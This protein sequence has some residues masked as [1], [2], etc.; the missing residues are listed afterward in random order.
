MNRSAFAN[1]S[2]LLDTVTRYIWGDHRNRPGWQVSLIRTMR[3]IWAV[4]RD[5]ME[6]QL[7]L[8]A[9]SLVY[10]TLLSLVPLLAISFSILKG[11]GVHNQIEPFLANA[12]EPLGER[13]D[14]VVNRIVD[15][16]DNVQVGVLGSVGF[17][18]LFYTVGSMMQK[19]EHAF[20]DVWQ[21]SSKRTF[22]QRFKDYLSVIVIGPVL[23]FA[24]LGIL[25][26]VMS[27]PLMERIVSIQPVSAVVELLARLVPIAI[28]TLAFTFIYMFVPHTRVRL[29]PAL[30]GGLVAG[31]LWNLLGWMFAAFVSQANRYTAIYSGFATPILFMMWLY[32]GWLVLLAGSAI[33]FYRQH[34]EYLSGRQLTGNLSS[35]DRER[36]ALHCICV[37]GERFYRGGSA[38]DADALANLL[39]VPSNAI[40]QVLAPLQRRGLIASTDAAPPGY[41]PGCPWETA[42]VNDVLEATHHAHRGPA[43]RAPPAVPHEAV[44]AVLEKRREILEGTFG[45]VTLKSLVTGS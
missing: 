1:G 13:R 40:E 4:G 36:L 12:L 10:T 41:L 5:V 6:G 29:I 19:I 14:E 33:A 34:P 16:V 35:A 30:T 32:F 28:V 25:A 17:I 43:E 15:F 42:S 22:T 8:Q 21:V 18:L 39:L 27:D 11:F 23:V 45:P 7:T 24:T 44:D 20:N 26:T 38:P 31:L 2:S 9:M 3:L 37:I